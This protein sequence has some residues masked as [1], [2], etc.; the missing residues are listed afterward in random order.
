[1]KNMEEIVHG[2]YPRCYCEMVDEGKLPLIRN[3]GAPGCNPSGF[4]MI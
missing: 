1:M 4:M 3:V 2:G